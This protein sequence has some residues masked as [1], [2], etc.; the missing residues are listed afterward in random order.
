[1]SLLQL[2]CKFVTPPFRRLHNMPSVSLL[3]EGEVDCVGKAEWSY[4][5]VMSPYFVLFNKDQALI[6]QHETTR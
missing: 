5:Y 4:G 2:V 6:K 1:M 3:S